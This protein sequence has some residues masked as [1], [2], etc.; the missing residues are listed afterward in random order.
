LLSRDCITNHVL[1]QMTQ[2]SI[3]N[4]TYST[5]NA[6]LWPQKSTV[7]KNSNSSVKM[8]IEPKSQFARDTEKSLPVFLTV[9]DFRDVT[10]PVE[11]FILWNCVLR[12]WDMSWWNVIYHLW[13]F[14]NFH[15][16]DYLYISWRLSTFCGK[17]QLW[18]LKFFPWVTFQS[19]SHILSNSDAV[20]P[21]N[22]PIVM[23]CIYYNF[24]Q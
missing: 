1:T 10:F 9:M 8:R 24:F 3:S 22:L 12:T 4:M 14:C 6:A 16:C 5:E 7:S 17:P 13:L 23:N 18:L 21:A 15:N 11:N 19:S 20:T 2:W